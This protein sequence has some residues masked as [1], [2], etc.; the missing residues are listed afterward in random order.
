MPSG[1]AAAHTSIFRTAFLSAVIE[2]VGAG[3]AYIFTLLTCI[4]LN[5]V[6][7]MHYFKQ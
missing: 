3:G 6:L 7:E 1:P 5:D 4:Y 2:I